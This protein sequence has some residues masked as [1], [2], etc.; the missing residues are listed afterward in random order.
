VNEAI[1]PGRS[2]QEVAREAGSEEHVLDYHH[3]A[4]PDET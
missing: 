1:A 2:L 4:C 3:M